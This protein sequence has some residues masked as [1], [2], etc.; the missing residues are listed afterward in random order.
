[1]V[2]GGSFAYL[3]MRPAL[4]GMGAEFGAR[5]YGRRGQKAAR[6][7]VEQIQAWHELARN[8]PEP[9]FAYWPTGTAPLHLSEGTAVLNKTNG[10]VMISWPTD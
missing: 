7:M 1:M 2:R 9:T 5:A 10:L 8:R 4:E 3:S 6:A